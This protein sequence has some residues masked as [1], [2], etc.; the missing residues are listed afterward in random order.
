M[1]YPDSPWDQYTMRRD[2]VSVLSMFRTTFIWS[3]ALVSQLR[4]H[5]VN[6][7]YLAFA[8]DPRDYRPPDPGTD[9]KPSALVL[10][11]CERLK[12]WPFE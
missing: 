3:H 1:L 11:G 4:S 8:H 6:S 9:P 2:V 10:P 12:A 5:G 7:E